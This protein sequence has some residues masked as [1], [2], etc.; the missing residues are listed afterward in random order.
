M[1]WSEHKSR[2]RRFLRDP[3]GNIWSDSLIL[4]LFNDEQKHFQN[5]INLAEDV[6]AVRIPPMFQMSYMHQWEWR[7]A[8]HTGYNYQ[9]F[10][11]YDPADMVFTYWYESEIIA[12]Q[13]SFTAD[14]NYHFTHP[15][16]AF[17]SG[18][19]PGDTPPLWCPR[20]FS[21]VVA[22]Y[23]DKKPLDPTTKKE[24][25]RD[26]RTW[27]TRTGEPQK[28]RRLDTLEN[29]IALYPIPSSVT[30]ND[31]T[32]DGSVLI[33]REDDTNSG[34]GFIYD[35]SG[36]MSNQ[37]S[38]VATDIIDPD[39]NN[40]LMVFKVVADDLEADDD[41]SDLPAYLTKYVE[42]SVL[43][44]AFGANT[45]GKIK[46]LANYWGLRREIGQKALEMFKS[47]R[48]VDRDYCLKTPGVPPRSTRRHPKLP[49]EYPAVW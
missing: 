41:E 28:Y 18:V 9:C 10:N 23:W 11:V 39:D 31:F 1:E 13:T 46:T 2:L 32:G 48:R 15:W 37:T 30:W 3:D 8:D 20:K 33:T 17:A 22:M 27:R 7:H 4:R 29:F 14:S 16:E 36:T 6:Q 25:T 49:D 43:E 34:T 24:I 26:D 44:R 47:K 21:R 42:F 19:T 35:A 40:L 5:A 38:G 12:N 45:D